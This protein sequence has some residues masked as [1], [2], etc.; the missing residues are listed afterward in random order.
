M[1]L[2]LGGNHTTQAVAEKHEMENYS[3][4]F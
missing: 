3:G 1:V 4:A 2:E